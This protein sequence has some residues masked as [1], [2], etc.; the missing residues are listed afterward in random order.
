MRLGRL[1]RKTPRSD[2]DS[3]DWSFREQFD[4]RYAIEDRRR[5]EAINPNLMDAYES[6]LDPAWLN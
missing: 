3:Y 6:S 1:Q 2:I 5:A 4:E